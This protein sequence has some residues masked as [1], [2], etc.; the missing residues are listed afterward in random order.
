MATHSIGVSA[1][2]FGLPKADGWEETRP[3]PHRQ[4]DRE[5]QYHFLR[6]AVVALRVEKSGEGRRKDQ[7]S[8][9]H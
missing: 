3:Q 9:R 7:R 8:A 5:R 4:R 1:E 2:P 6:R